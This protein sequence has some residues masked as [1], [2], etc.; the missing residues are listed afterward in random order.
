MS[1]DIDHIDQRHLDAIADADVRAWVDGPGQPTDRVSEDIRELVREMDRANNEPGRVRGRPI[2][3]EP[4]AS[5][6]LERL[7]MPVGLTT[8]GK[9]TSTPPAGRTRSRSRRPASPPS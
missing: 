1:D 6:Q 7:T 4:P 8:S 2:P 5:E 9:D 3:L